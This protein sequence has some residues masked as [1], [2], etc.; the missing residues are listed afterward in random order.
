M[1]EAAGAGHQDV[2]T[3]THIAPGIHTTGLLGASLQEQAVVV[4]TEEGLIV[5]TGCAHPGIVAIVQK[6]IGK[7]V[8]SL[9]KLGVRRVAPSHCTGDPARRQFKEAYGAD[10]VEG[11][12][13]MIL[14][15]AAAK[16]PPR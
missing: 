5:I 2:S 6:A 13:G 1:I 3:P 10:Y 14:K 9:R 16:A 4:E 11:G 7:I 12:A 15:F 8:Q